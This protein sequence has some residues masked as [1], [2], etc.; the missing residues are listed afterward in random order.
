MRLDYVLVPVYKSGEESIQFI[1]E[2]M[3][4]SSTVAGG[5]PP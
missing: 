3:T 4:E 5:M 2:S 1:D